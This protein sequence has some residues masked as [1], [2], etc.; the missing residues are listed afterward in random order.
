VKPVF[1]CLAFIFVL[2]LGLSVQAQEVIVRIINA[3][4]GRPLQNQAISVSFLYDRKYDKEIPAKHDAVLHLETNASGDAHFG[5]PEPPPAH[6]SAQVRVDWS[7][8]KC[9]CWLLGSTDELVRKGIVGPKV[10]TDKSASD[11][12]P[13]PGEILFVARPLSWFERLLYPLTRE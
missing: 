5:F 10:G 12:K 9:G 11:I 2:S 6:F 1:R 7:H 3:A 4:D 13:V 8:W